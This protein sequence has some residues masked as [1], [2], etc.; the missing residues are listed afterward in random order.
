MFVPEAEIT[1]L[2]GQSARQMP[3]RNRLMMLE[4][5][6]A[7]FRKHRGRFETAMFSIVFKPAVIL[8]DVCHIAI[9]LAAYVYGLVTLDARR[10][11]KSSMKIR[12]AARFLTIY[13][14]RFLFK[15]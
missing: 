8:R 5:M 1:H 2:G 9:G 3:A 4:S 11:G 15:M 7:F 14:Y 13:L 12:N 10:R 6:F